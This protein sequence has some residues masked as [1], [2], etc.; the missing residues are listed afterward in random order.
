VQIHSGAEVASKSLEITV[1][2]QAAGSD[3]VATKPEITSE[4]DHE[5]GNCRS[6]CKMYAIY[7][8]DKCPRIMFKCP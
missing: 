5:A 1:L 2:S 8:P 7:V 4:G 3:E 6:W